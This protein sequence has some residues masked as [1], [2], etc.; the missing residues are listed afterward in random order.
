[1]V[2]RKEIFK[3]PDKY[4]VEN[5]FNKT[6]RPTS[7]SPK[8]K[9]YY[10]NSL[11]KADKHSKCTYKHPDTGKRCINLLGLY[12]E[13]CELHTMLINNIY[14]SKSNIE[15]AG[16]GLYTGQYGFKKGDIIGQYNYKWNSVKLDTIIKRCENKDTK[17]WKYVFCDDSKNNIGKDKIPCWDA[18]DIRSTLMRNINDAYKSKFRNNC[19]FDVIN[20]NVYIIASRNIKPH[21]ELFVSYGKKY[22]S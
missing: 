1:M 20:G 4:F 6:N 14:I 9:T 5:N 7:P 8:R 18:L 12:P 16:N 3:N 21:K 19:Y 17:C 15:E 13:Y 22:W 11:K 10:K 2:I